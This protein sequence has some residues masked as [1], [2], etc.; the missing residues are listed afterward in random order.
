[1]N[2]TSYQCD[3]HTKAAFEKK[4]DAERR[5]MRQADLTL[6]LSINNL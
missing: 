5:A 4:T 6:L 3:P 1:L 2:L